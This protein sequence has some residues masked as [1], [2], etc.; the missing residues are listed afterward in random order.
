MDTLSILTL[1]L[2]AAWAS[3]INPCVTVLVLG[4]LGSAGPITLP[5][6]LAF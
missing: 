4:L 3:G 2:G 5:D 1:A 6:G